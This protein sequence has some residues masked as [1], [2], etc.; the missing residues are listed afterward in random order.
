MLLIFGL[1]IGSIISNWLEKKMV[2]KDKSKKMSNSLFV[3]VSFLLIMS[4]YFF[5]FLFDFIESNPNLKNWIVLYPSYWYSNILLYLIDPLLVETYIIN[6]WMSIVLAIAVPLIIFY[7]SYKKANI[8]YDIELPFGA[9]QH[10][11]TREKKYFQFLRRVTPERYH[12]LIM[13]QFK[14]F[15]RIV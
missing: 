10:T 11:I 8:F 4:F 12:N 1:L 2:K 5:H 6:I 15:F 14:E 13:T 3:L 7:I 9:N